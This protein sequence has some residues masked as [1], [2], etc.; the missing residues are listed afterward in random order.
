MPKWSLV[1]AFMFAGFVQ[2]GCGGD[3]GEADALP[4]GAEVT[5]VGETSSALGAT[6]ASYSYDGCGDQ[7]VGSLCTPPLRARLRYMQTGTTRP[8]SCE[9]VI[10]TLCGC[11][12]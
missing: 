9:V 12:Y 1:F 2:V 7:P 6:C 8:P 11:S 4:D 5:E 3:P 10:G